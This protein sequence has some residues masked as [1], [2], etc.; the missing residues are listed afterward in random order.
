MTSGRNDERDRELTELSWRLHDYCLLMRVLLSVEG[1]AHVLDA[2][3]CALHVVVEFANLNNTNIVVVKWYSLVLAIWQLALGRGSIPRGDIS[4]CL[5][6]S[7]L[8]ITIFF[9]CPPQL[10][11]STK[12]HIQVEVQSSCTGRICQYPLNASQ[13]NHFLKGATWHCQAPCLLRIRHWQNQ[14]EASIMLSAP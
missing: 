10:S 7:L 2:E 12:S 9:P 11:S 6:A 3:F 1:R 13:D 8:L 14:P 4:F 5:T